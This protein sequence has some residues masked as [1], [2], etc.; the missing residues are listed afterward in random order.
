M[1]SF[2]PLVACVIVAGMMSASLPP[3]AGF[4]QSE[5]L[6]KNPDFALGPLYWETSQTGCT[7]LTLPDSTSLKSRKVAR[8][9]A[10]G[11]S[12]SKC[13]LRQDI[14]TTTGTI[15]SAAANL[16]VLQLGPR[17]P[18]LRLLWLSP[19][20]APVGTMVA[21]AE[22]LGPHRLTLAQ[23]APPGS[24]SVR[25]EIMADPGAPTRTEVELVELRV[26]TAPNVPAIPGELFVSAHETGGA[27]L[28]WA[29]PA[30]GKL[31]LRGFTL[32][33]DDGQG[34]QPIAEVGPSRTSYWDADAASGPVRY[35]VQA[36][37]L[38]GSGAASESS[39]MTLPSSAGSANL[40]Q[41]PDFENGLIGWRPVGDD[42]FCAVG[43][44]TVWATRSSVRI[45][46]GVPD[47]AWLKTECGVQ[48]TVVGAPVSVAVLSADVLIGQ[49]SPADTG[50]LTLFY[51]DQQGNV[52][53]VCRSYPRFDGPAQQTIAASCP[54]ISQAVRVVAFLGNGGLL[55][56]D[57]HARNVQ[58]RSDV[59]VAP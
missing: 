18:S 46:S 21:A 39:W 29:Q 20:G 5:N 27:W 6:V 52:L 28:Q 4:P 54:T 13:A 49:M 10:S 59:M 8:M 3:A 30:M 25:I 43:V 12:A 19:Q 11:A 40:L 33:R 38:I 58:L 14:I 51:A 15:Y 32:S 23:A 37:N 26:V 41:N 50:E 48:Q 34:M 9:D 22:E 2:G 7:S 1:R 24:A 35:S 57:F 44:D 17:G 42:E 55:A 16:N 53:R 31:P 56:G 36:W 47:P 45:T